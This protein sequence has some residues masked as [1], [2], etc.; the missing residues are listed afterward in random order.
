MGSFETD[1][2]QLK[3]DFEKVI[4]TLEEIDSENVIEKNRQIELLTKSIARK[5]Q[6]LVNNH[7]AKDLKKINGEFDKLIKQIIEKFDNIIETKKTEQHKIGV[8]LRNSL[9]AKK[10]VKYRRM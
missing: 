4:I 8:E 10:L 6:N 3:N 9:N 7:L 5:R 2:F 1:V